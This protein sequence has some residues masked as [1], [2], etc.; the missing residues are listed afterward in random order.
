V[1]VLNCSDQV[2][3]KD[4]KAQA[5]VG[6]LQFQFEPAS[7]SAA[8]RKEGGKRDE[9]HGVRLIIRSESA[10]ALSSKPG[11]YYA[12]LYIREGNFDES[13]GIAF[14]MTDWVGRE[15]EEPGS[16]YHNIYGDTLVREFDPEVGAETLSL[17][18]LKELQPD[19]IAFEYVLGR[20]NGQ[21]I[22]IRCD[23]IPPLNADVPSTCSLAHNLNPTVGYEVYLS[24]K[25][26]SHWAEIHLL[27]ENLIS[28]SLR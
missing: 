7:V 10:S 24:R 16:I 15:A 3:I 23:Q 13:R 14:Q 25:F 20:V 4:G 27:A 5:Q 12:E 26:L 19:K 2:N 22:V 9:Y 28:A 11:H 1:F 17:P 18:P 6:N 8:Y 21:V